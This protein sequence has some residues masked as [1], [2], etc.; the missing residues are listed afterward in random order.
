MKWNAKRRSFRTIVEFEAG[1]RGA[2]AAELLQ[3]LR[4]DGAD[5]VTQW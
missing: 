4:G 2:C 1:I 5:A 3:V